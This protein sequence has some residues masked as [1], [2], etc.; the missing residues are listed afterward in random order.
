MHK[1]GFFVISIVLCL[2]VLRTKTQK[3]CRNEFNLINSMCP[4]PSNRN[5][6]SCDDCLEGRWSE[7]FSS[8]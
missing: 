1:S 5:H 6:L 4:L 8:V 3:F 7:L 2:V